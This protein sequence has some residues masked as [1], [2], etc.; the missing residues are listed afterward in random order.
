MRCFEGQLCVC[1][2]ISLQA[3]CGFQPERLLLE[4][5]KFI[6]CLCRATA[7]PLPGQLCSSGHDADASSS[8]I[9]EIAV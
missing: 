6:L 3:F 9:I 4:R 2:L 5:M 7:G 8:E 1:G